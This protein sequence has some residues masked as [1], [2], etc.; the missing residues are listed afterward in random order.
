MAKRTPTEI[1]KDFKRIREA[2][3]TAK[4]IADLE[5]ATGLSRIMINTTLEKHPI[6]RARIMERLQANKEKAK[7][8]A[9]HSEKNDSESKK[10]MDIAED[11]HKY[12]ID[13]SITGTVNMRS[14]L[15]KIQS[16]DASNIVLTSITIRELKKLE[17]LRDIQGFDATYIMN[18]ALDYPDIYKPVL[19]DETIGTPDDCIMKYCADNKEKLTLLTADKEMALNARMYGVEVQFMRYERT[20]KEKTPGRTPVRKETLIPAVIINGKLCIARFY[21]HKMSIRVYSEGI[22]YNSGIKELKVGDDVL[23]AKIKETYIVFAHYRMTSLDKTNN[24]ELVFSRRI[25][26]IYKIDSLEN[27]KYRTFIK[28]FRYIHN[29]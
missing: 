7:L 16:E 1:E 4:S 2:A 6:V 23:I 27:E 10:S 24:C 21:T 20:N 26:D 19:I 22:E 13:A 29:L 25:P 3:E 18:R 11:N 8:K 12:V 28:D 17:S 5:R 14:I 15:E 9:Q